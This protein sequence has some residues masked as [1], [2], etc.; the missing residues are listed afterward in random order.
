MSAAGRKVFGEPSGDCLQEEVPR[1]GPKINMMTTLFD[2]IFGCGHNH[3]SFPITV[4][5]RLPESGRQS[6]RHLRGMPGLRKG[7]ALRLGGNESDQFPGGQARSLASPGRETGRLSDDS[8]KSTQRP[9]PRGL[10][11][12]FCRSKFCRTNKTGGQGRRKIEAIREVRSSVAAVVPAFQGWTVVV[13]CAAAGVGASF[14]GRG[15]PP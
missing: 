2:T 6:D 9:H 14:I 11:P 5:S 4:R 3:C 10:R 1:R 13:T 7:N 8:R 15:G 12:L